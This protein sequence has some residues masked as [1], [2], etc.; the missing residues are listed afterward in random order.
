MSSEPGDSTLSTYTAADGDNLAVQDW[1]APESRRVRGLV[2]L[3]HGLGEHAG[4]YERLARRLNAW[5]FAV[6]GYD[7][8]GH[9]ESGGTR[10]CLPTPTRLVDDLADIVGS[11]RGRLPER[12]PLIVFG[13]SLGGL[14]A[15]CFALRR[16]RPPIDGLVLSS[17]ALDPGLTR[18]Q[19]LLLAV[20]PRVAPNLTVG[21]GL[22]PRFLSHDPAVVAA[23]RADPRVH[24]R[25]SGRLA[26]FVAEAGPQVVARAPQWKLPTLLVYAGDDRLVN[27]TGSRRFAETAPPEVVTA[28]R[29]DALYHEIFNEREAEPVYATLKVWLDERFP[30]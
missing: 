22:D 12:L 5:G 1:P 11:V 17:P 20:L 6:R 18:W 14:V 15:A 13:H 4:R 26:R 7:Q 10:G 2:V 30:A 19:K 16:G 29:F 23:Y 21:N 24:D 25:I 3:V 8:C 9:G 28:R 27:A